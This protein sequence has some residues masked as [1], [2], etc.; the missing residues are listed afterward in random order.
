MKTK[1]VT[2]ILFILLLAVFIS[3]ISSYAASPAAISAKNIRQKLVE[4]VMNPEDMATV[5]S[6]GEAEVLFK[7]NDEGTIDIR[8]IDA[9]NEDVASFVKST[10]ANVPC[11]DF[12]HPYNQY[13]KVKFRFTQN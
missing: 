4:A 13:Y 6:T 11:K 1:N 7:L 3:A 5:P 2:R 9:T 12:V 8:K 10:M